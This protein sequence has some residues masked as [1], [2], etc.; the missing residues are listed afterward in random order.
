MGYIVVERNTILNLSKL[1]L[2]GG[3]TVKIYCVGGGGGGGGGSGGKKP[4]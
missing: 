4:G 3:D 1:G 2:K